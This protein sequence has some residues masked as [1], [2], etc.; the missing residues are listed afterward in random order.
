[1]KFMFI[2]NS[3]MSNFCN[4][5]WNFS[6]TF[7]HEITTNFPELFK[8]ENDKPFEALMK[9][10]VD[11]RQ[12][13]MPAL[14][15][16]NINNILSLYGLQSLYCILLFTDNYHFVGSADIGFMADGSSVTVS[17][18]FINKPYRGRKYGKLLMNLIIQKIK[19]Y[20]NIKKIILDVDFN[21][22]PAN[23]L[24]TSVGFVPI[25]NYGS[26]KRRMIYLTI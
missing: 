25:D 22:I 3:E 18:F 5:H 7:G 11:R 6:K 26:N 13:I 24:Y 19:Q 15:Y 12:N 21:N 20:P 1:M 8:N 23:K 14:Y 2:K 16:K 4:K 17:N 9:T 10:C